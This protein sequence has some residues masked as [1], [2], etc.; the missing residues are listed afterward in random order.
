[1]RPTIVPPSTMAARPS[2]RPSRRTPEGRRVAR[3]LAAFAALGLGIGL[4]GPVSS[5]SPALG[6]EVA[7]APASRD[8]P[9]PHSEAVLVSGVSW[10]RS[11]EP[12]TVG[13][14]LTL[15]PGW[16]SYWKNPGDSGEPISIE[17][18][19]PEGFV[20][21]EIRWPVPERIPFPP[22]VSYGYF[23]QVLFPVEI[24]PP[25]DL[26]P[27]DS[28]RLAGRAH[29][30]VCIEDCF[31]AEA[32]LSL[33]LPVRAATPEPDPATTA[34]FADARSRIPGVD[35]RWT[36]AA[37][38]TESWYG[39]RLEPPADLD[40]AALSGLQFFA[41]DGDVIDHAAEQAWDV[42]GGALVVRLARSG[43]A[44]GVADT[45]RGVLVASRARAPAPADDA[46]PVDGA[47]LAVEFAAPVEVA[48]GTTAEGPA[49]GAGTES[50][51]S[52]AAL[53]IGLAL[54][55]AFLGGLILN[56]MPCVFPILGIKVLGFVGHAEEGRGGAARQGGAFAAGVLASFWVLGGLLLVLRAAGESV[57]WG[58]QLQSPPFVG[59][60]AL[61]FFLLALALLGAFEI[62]VSLTRLGMFGNGKIPSTYRTEPEAGKVPAPKPGS[63]NRAAQ[64]FG[65]GILATVVATPCTAPF[66]G[67]ALGWALIR[68]PVETMLVFTAL[69][70]GMAAPY[71]ALSL[72]PGLLERLPPPGRWMETLKQILAFPLLATVVWLA[73][74]FGLQTGV[75]GVAGLLA[76]LLLAGLAAWVAGRWAGLAA[77]PGRRHV[78]RAVAV[79]IG[80]G[81]LFVLVRA[82]GAT[83]GGPG[84][85]AVSGAGAEGPG[86]WRPWSPAA[87]AEAR[88]SG[89]P[90]LLDFT[91]AWCLSCQV[92][93]RVV[94]NTAAIREA[95]RAH[96][97]TLL[98]ADWTRRDPAITAALAELG[99]SSVPVYALYPRGG[100]DPV[101]LPSVLT[102]EIVLDALETHAPAR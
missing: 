40:A 48:P 11:G 10:V 15:E 20:A 97:V 65:T 33:S 69:G 30:L 18:R 92:N 7:T 28:M 86:G 51:V 3:G 1:M 89:E 16:H 88:A 44:T 45:L 60:M 37:R 12:F 6:Q 27:G 9:S 19:L 82:S 13:L 8:D 94:L 25:A 87:V 99:R 56:L 42:D 31:P 4:D 90:L 17:W 83:P 72:S 57:G 102:R 55:F 59:A 101:L 43:F 24:A 29:W 50:R 80:I 36:A 93:E 95:F 26:A 41:A 47:A 39:L 71:V 38:A 5:P 58:F 22:L 49:I 14:R 98:K 32:E 34:A 54:V 46:G 63:R 67:A 23:D 81:A 85:A 84:L 70:A 2:S 75:G 21:G 66:M 76:A 79:A 74:V 100:G 77:R 61:L 35:P 52:A 53:G 73:W 91:A 96:G 78:A 68:P 64:S 62:G